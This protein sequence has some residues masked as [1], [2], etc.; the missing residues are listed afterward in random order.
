[1]NEEF[2]LKFNSFTQ[3]HPES[4]DYFC[5]HLA[6]GGFERSDVLTNLKRDIQTEKFYSELANSILS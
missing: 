4:I 3:K 5:K 1:V 6:K 2:K